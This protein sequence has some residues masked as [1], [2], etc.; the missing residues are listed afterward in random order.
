MLQMR[1]ASTRRLCVYVLLIAVLCLGASA[2]SADGGKRPTYRPSEDEVNNI[3]DLTSNEKELKCTSCRAI[4][5]EVHER[6]WKVSQLRHGHPKHFE[7]VDV[8][9]SVCF[10]M[11]SSYGLL[12]KNNAPTTEFS[13]NDKISRYQGSWINTYLER[14]CGDVLHHFDDDL[15]RE[16]LRHETLDAFRHVVC[17][18]W[19]KSCMTRAE[20]VREDL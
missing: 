18:T 2:R 9:D 20:A 13:R 4:A 5:R 19:E 1:S 11:A 8:L 14:R 16:A 3:P 12:L 6:L 7:L 10:D 15:I 17:T